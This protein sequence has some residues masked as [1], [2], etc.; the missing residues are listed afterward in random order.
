MNEL[1][2]EALIKELDKAVGIKII[3]YEQIKRLIEAQ[4]ESSEEWIKRMTENLRVFAGWES[5][6]ND[7]CEKFVRDHLLKEVLMKKP[8]VSR[9]FSKSWIAA[10][11]LP[12]AENIEAL[13]E[14]VRHYIAEL[15][16]NCDPPSLVRDNIVIKENI[17]ALE[18]RLKE[19]EA[20]K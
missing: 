6:M 18:V 17:K 4:A 8:K 12:T 1:S 11:W 19:A 9:E 2:K 20:K 15:E 13:P 14:P 10:S 3:A 16:T 7:T 5:G